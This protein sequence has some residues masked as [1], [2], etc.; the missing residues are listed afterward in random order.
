[1]SSNTIIATRESRLALW[2]AEHVRDVLTARFGLAVELLGMTTKGDQILDRA[3]SK[4]GGKGLFVKELETALEEGRAHLAVHSLKD[5]PM[6]LPPG[7]AL[8]AI[9]ERED[10]RDAWVSNQYENLDALPQG[11]CVG[12]S[13][14]RRVVQ[15][16]AHRPDLKIEPLRGNLD[17]RLR[18]LDE[19]GYDAI[20]L[21]AAGLK[22]LGLGARIRS[23]FDTALMIPAAGQGALGIEIREDD[24]RL[25]ELLAQ[26]IHQP[27]FLA[28]HA[29]RAVS[30][31]LGGSCSMPLAAFGHWNDGVLT[32]DAAL[33]HST[34]LTRPLIKVRVSGT[35]TD[36]A[37]A[38]ALGEH[39]AALLRQAGAGDYLPAC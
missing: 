24:A 11:A 23:L 37:S 14:L 18:K 39:A 5:V 6:D 33:G 1:M 27:T 7:F 35:P 36:E 13:S 3:L 38:R 20:V 25:R 31:S 16:L 22:R 8:A 28:C 9:W 21:A 29:E 30:R 17:T 12:T 10:P 15:L 32:I 26:T 2:Q 4:V 34:E 19:G